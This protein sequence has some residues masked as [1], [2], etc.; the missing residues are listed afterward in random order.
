MAI[1]P[2]RLVEASW[3][4]KTLTLT[5]NLE[6]RHDDSEQFPLPIRIRFK[7]EK[8][9]R[10]SSRFRFSCEFGNTFDILLEGKGTY[11]EHEHAPLSPFPR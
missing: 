3:A 1:I 8:N 9:C 2:Q 5:E 11:E 6:K 4:T 7:P 10:Y